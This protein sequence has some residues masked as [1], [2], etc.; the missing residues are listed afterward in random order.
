VDFVGAAKAAEF[1]IRLFYFHLELT[2]LNKARVASRVKSE[3]HK[4]P[5]AKVESRNPG[6]LMNLRER[7]NQH[8]KTTPTRST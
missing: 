4:V 6:T 3:G 5:E 2:S 1:R 8:I 7:L